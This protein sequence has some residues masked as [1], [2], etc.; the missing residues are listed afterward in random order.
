MTIFDIPT[1]ER[2][3]FYKDLDYLVAEDK[4]LREELL[5]EYVASLDEKR[6]GEVVECVRREM[7]AD[8]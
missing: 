3:Q 5:D 7:G 6:F 8:L 1:K 2:V 4:Y